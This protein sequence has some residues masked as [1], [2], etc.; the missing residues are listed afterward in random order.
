MIFSCL[1]FGSLEMTLVRE[2]VWCC[3]HDLSLSNLKDYLGDLEEVNNER[4]LLDLLN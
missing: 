2:D 3:R 1:I 4:Y